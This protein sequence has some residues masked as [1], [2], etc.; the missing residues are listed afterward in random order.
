MTLRLFQYL[1]G[2]N[3]PAHALRRRALRMVRLWPHGHDYKAHRQLPDFLQV[4]VLAAL[5]QADGIKVRT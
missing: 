2:H 3:G 5:S 1:T 4:D